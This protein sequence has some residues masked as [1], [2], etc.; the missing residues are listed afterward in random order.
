MNTQLESYTSWFP[1]PFAQGLD[2]FQIPW[3]D[4]KGY[5]FPPFLNDMLLSGKD[6]KGSGN[7]YSDNTNLAHKSMVPSPF[8]NVLQR[9][10]SSAP[11]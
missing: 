3:S 9:A 4:L 8:R 2:A 5:S 10:T 11:P 6:P 7:N 1:D